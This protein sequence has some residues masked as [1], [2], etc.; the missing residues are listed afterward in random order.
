MAYNGRKV[1]SAFEDFDGHI[2]FNSSEQV[3]RLN[4]ES[5]KIQ[6]INK[7]DGLITFRLNPLSS[8]LTRKGEVI[9][10]GVGGVTY[11]DP[12]TFKTPDRPAQYCNLCLPF[13]R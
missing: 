12:R 11:F 3:S 4:P 1:V 10:A 7:S 13:R 2:W 9:F 6:S 8:I 5:A